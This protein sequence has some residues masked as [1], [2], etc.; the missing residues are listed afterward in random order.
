[1]MSLSQNIIDQIID[2]KV[3]KKY[4]IYTIKD[5]LHIDKRTVKRHLSNAGLITH[6]KTNN[7]LSDK[8]ISRIREL[9]LT[10]LSR[11]HIADRLNI[12]ENTV[13]K[14]SKLHKSDERYNHRKNELLN[15][16]EKCDYNLQKAGKMLGKIKPISD[17]AIEKYGLRDIIEQHNKL[18]KLHRKLVVA[19]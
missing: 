1:M 3:N 7:K 18:S 14:Y 8:D 11:Q 10:G 17:F 12:S 15:I 13:C 16:L 19:D 4:G 5:I 9:E 6:K 2:L